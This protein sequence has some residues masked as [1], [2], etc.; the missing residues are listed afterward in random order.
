MRQ[1]LK[2]KNL[3]KKLRRVKKLGQITAEKAGKIFD[4]I[5]VVNDSITNID[6][7]IGAL[8]R[9]ALSGFFEN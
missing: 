2:N 3:I 7:A 9:G 1:M 8:D 4:D 6:T 5:K